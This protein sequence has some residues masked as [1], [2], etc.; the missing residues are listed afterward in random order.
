VVLTSI[1]TYS[2]KDNLNKVQQ[3]L[4]PRARIDDCQRWHDL[5][6]F[7]RKLLADLLAAGDHWAFK[8]PR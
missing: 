4:F 7:M 5:T 3:F 2:T 1:A 8:Q 6:S